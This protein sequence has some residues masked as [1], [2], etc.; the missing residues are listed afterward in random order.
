M[1]DYHN[2]HEKDVR[3][4]WV[5]QDF[6]YDTVE[7]ATKYPRHEIQEL[8][9]KFDNFVEIN[10]LQGYIDISDIITDALSITM[11]SD[12]GYSKN[13]QQS[14]SWW[15]DYFTQLWDMVSAN[16]ETE[17]YQW[18]DQISAVAERAHLLLNFFVL[19]LTIHLEDGEREYLACNVAMF[20]DLLGYARYNPFDNPYMRLVGDLIILPC[21]VTNECDDDDKREIHSVYLN[22]LDRRLPT[23]ASRTRRDSREPQRDRQ[24]TSSRS[25]SRSTARDFGR[26]R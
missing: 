26:A 9:E 4:L 16:E 17:D 12:Y 8:I 7:G 22:A 24:S 15:V 20:D 14:V 25:T 1:K 19:G 18:S 10:N 5:T 11:R 3:L 13:N 6:H 21:L 2:Y 23:N